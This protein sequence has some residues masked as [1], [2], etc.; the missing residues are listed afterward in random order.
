[1]VKKA[2]KY[3]KLFGFDQEIIVFLFAKLFGI[4]LLV[5][6]GPPHCEFGEG[7]W[8]QGEAALQTHSFRD[9]D[10]QQVIPLKENKT[11]EFLPSSLDQA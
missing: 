2:Y 5:K 11:I 9:A 4:F 6:I 3:Y 7:L 10:P 1:M 8:L